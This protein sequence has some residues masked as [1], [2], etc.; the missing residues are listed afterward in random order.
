[1]VTRRWFLP[2]IMMLTLGLLPSLHAADGSKPLTKGPANV[3][4]LRVMQKRVQELVKKVMPCTVGVQ[5]GGSAGSGVIVSEDGYVLTAGH[6]SGK[7]GQDATLILPDGRR[8]KGKTLGAN[9]GIDSGMIKITEEGKWPFVEL[10]DSSKLEKGQWCFSLGHPGGYRNG[11]SPVLRVGRVLNPAD[12]FIQTDCTL[13]G[14]DSGGP[15]FDFDGRLIGIHSRIGLS[16]AFNIHVPVDTYRHTW[17]RLAKGETW[18]SM[19]TGAPAKS[20]P[21]IDGVEFRFLMGVLVINEIKTGSFAE[22]A[23]LKARDH[24]SKLEGQ[25]VSTLDDVKKILQKK[26]VGDEVTVEVQRGEQT[27]TLKVQLSKA[28]T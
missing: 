22:K 10:G 8:I 21:S 26:K 9:S 19:L 20:E 16:I 12:T 25:A 1:M 7:P 24:L 4:E 23:G 3:A 5:I 27:L 6:V 2:G 15:L 18:G 11:R 13:V 28:K 17:E 14:G